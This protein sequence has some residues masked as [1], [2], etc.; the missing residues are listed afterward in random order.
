MSK[1]ETLL[2]YSP[3]YKANPHIPFP[4]WKQHNFTCPDC[5]LQFKQEARVLIKNESCP[6]CE[7]K[8]PSPF[9]NLKTEFPKIAAEWDTQL[10]KDVPEDLLPLSSQKRHFVC[11]DCDEKYEATIA[12]RTNLNSGCPYCAGNRINESTSLFKLRPDLVEEWNWDKNI[13]S[14]KE[15]GLGSHGKIHWKCK[16]GHE[17]QASIDNRT[18]R[19]D[20]CP[21]CYGRYATPENNFALVFPEKAK[22]WHPTKNGTKTPYDYKPTSNLNE[23]WW[24]CGDCSNEYM[25]SCYVKSRQNGC[26]KC[27]GKE[28]TEKN[29]ILAKSNITL[30]YWDYEKNELLPEQVHHGSNKKMHFKCQD[31]K[32]EWQIPVH[33]MNMRKYGCV[34]CANLIVHEKNNFKHNYP[35]LTVFWDY[36]KND[37]LPSEIFPKTSKQFFFKCASGHSFSRSVNSFIKS[38]GS[39]PICFGESQFSRIEKKLLFELKW[40]FPNIPIDNQVIATVKGNW[41]VDILIDHLKLIIEYDGK[42]WHSFEKKGYRDKTKNSIFRDTGYTII[43]IR[44]SP[45]KLVSILDIPY[46]VKNN[47]ANIKTTIDALLTTIA[48]NFPISPEESQRI[49]MYL[50]SDCFLN[51]EAYQEFIELPFETSNSGNPWD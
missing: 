4:I 19:G 26:S 31:C 11:P 51:E 45:L 50:E 20:G 23:C 38:N 28:L 37:K 30:Q 3:E 33:S 9:Y 40:I 24:V 8:R 6:Y 41:S 17:Y 35:K 12:N 29:T 14:P 44:E 34:K 27:N 10:N 46:D 39:C 25:C 42:H 1:E 7:K 18:R 43:R 49:Q 21:F 2:K 48:Q 32:H 22:D 5:N 47:Y 36:D 15:V 13:K 16:N